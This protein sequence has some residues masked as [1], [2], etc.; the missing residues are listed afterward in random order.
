MRTG[1]GREER[2]ARRVRAF[3]TSYLRRTTLR[4]ARALPLVS[5]IRYTPDESALPSV[6]VALQRTECIPADCSSSTS[7][8]T[9]RPAASYATRVTRPAAAV[10]YSMVVA[11][12]N[13]FGY[14]TSEAAR[15]AGV[16]ST[17]VT[18]ALRAASASI[19]PQ[20]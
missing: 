18:M 13:G 4:L 9:R 19:T 5:V 10:S 14:A 2:Y 6:S 11:G 16:S 7:T 3:E 12:L 15:E 20:P 17:P 8:A 1:R